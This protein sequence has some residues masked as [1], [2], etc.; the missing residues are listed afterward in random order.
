MEMSE[1]RSILIEQGTQHWVEMRRSFLTASELPAAAGESPYMSRAQLMRIK[2]G[3]EEQDSTNHAMIRG[4]QAEHAARMILE[5]RLQQDLFPEVVARTVEGLQLLASLD[6]ITLDG[7][8]IFEHKLYS[9]ALADSL[10]EGVIPSHHLLQ[11]QQQMLV[12]G[13]KRC[14]YVVSDGTESNWIEREV[15]PDEGVFRRIVSIWRRFVEDAGRASVCVAKAVA[16]VPA[17]VRFDTAALGDL[18]DQMEALIAQ[19]DAGQ[20]SVVVA[21]IKRASSGAKAYFDDELSRLDGGLPLLK[22]MRLWD[23]VRELRIKAEKVVAEEKDKVLMQIALD[24]VERFPER[25]RGAAS[26]HVRA[27]IARRKSEA[28]ARDAASSIAERLYGEAE[29]KDVVTMEEIARVCEPFRI[30]A[31]ILSEC[32]VGGVFYDKAKVKQKLGQLF[33]LASGA[34]A[35]W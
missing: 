12:S 31:A 17:Q 16:D 2:R 14:L 10:A 24:S 21:A 33:L 11:M 35:G 30:D 22:V 23:E 32:L 7:E 8:T 34:V 3:E 5:R 20:L 9:A 26:G 19:R 18:R 29:G 25:L 6:G 15:L 13:A 27:E 28:T 1:R 4:Q